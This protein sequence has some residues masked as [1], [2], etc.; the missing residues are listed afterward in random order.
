MVEANAN[1]YIVVSVSYHKYQNGAA[2]NP[3]STE[4]IFFEFWSDFSVCFPLGPLDMR[5]E[6]NFF[7]S[8]P[9]V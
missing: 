1:A 8:L 3:A 2:I 7:L 9:E 4:K 5:S 6:R